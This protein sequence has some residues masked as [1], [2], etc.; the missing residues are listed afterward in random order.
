MVKDLFCFQCGIKLEGNAKYCIECGALVGYTNCQCGQIIPPR[1]NFCPS[2]SRKV[3]K[4]SVVEMKKKGLVR[5]DPG[6]V[7]A[8]DEDD[9]SAFIEVSDVEGVFSKGVLIPFGTEALL[10][11][12]GEYIMTLKSGNHT[13]QNLIDSIRGF[14]VKRAK[15]IFFY[16]ASDIVLDFNF[17]NLISKLDGQE[18]SIEFQGVFNIYDAASFLR[19]IVKDFQQYKKDNLREY[20]SFEL[21]DIIDRL[22]KQYKVIDLCQD[23]RIRGELELKILQEW[24][25]S[26]MRNGIKVVQVR[27]LNVKSAVIQD[28][29][30]LRRDSFKENYLVDEKLAQ[31]LRK[32]EQFEK[33]DFVISKEREEELKRMG[34]DK[35]YLKKKIDLYKSLMEQENLKRFVEA[36]SEKEREK[37]L[38]EIDKEKILLEEEKRELLYDIEWAK[39]KD[40]ALAILWGSKLK[41]ILDM[42]DLRL[43]YDKKLYEM[44]MDGKITEKMRQEEMKMFLQELQKKEIIHQQEIKEEKDRLVLEIEKEKKEHELSKEWFSFC[45][46]LEEKEEELKHKHEMEKIREQNRSNYEELKIKANMTAAQL[47]YIVLEAGVKQKASAEEIQAISQDEKV[48]AELLE[49]IINEIKLQQNIQRADNQFIIEQFVAKEIAQA[50]A[51][52]ETQRGHVADIKEVSIGMTHPLKEISCPNCGFVMS[53]P[54]DLCPKCH[55]NLK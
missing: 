28:L 31:R 41:H 15:R 16:E 24:S 19:N 25:T 4:Y 32:V 20:F 48:M 42:E 50:K 43:A 38:W 8:R 46:S 10:F 12:G 40:Q 2:C 7:W 44:E 26:L 45:R 37:I 11:E 6:Y 22:L 21:K 14:S 33:E 35:D 13:L 52:V 39:A 55:Y 27:I 49:R 5:I 54:L 18:F 34:L 29:Y 3:E 36:K 17:S 9:I 51:Q 53:T 30:S 47:K 23:P 1:A